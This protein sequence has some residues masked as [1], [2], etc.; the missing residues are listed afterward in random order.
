M[1]KATCP[2]KLPLSIKKAVQRLAK[3]DATAVSCQDFSP[4]PLASV[5]AVLIDGI[6]PRRVLSPPM[7]NSHRPDQQ[8][9]GRPGLPPTARQPRPCGRRGRQWISLSDS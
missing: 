8:P 3:E 1:S 6:A 7:G 9:G 5:A 4:E 2:L